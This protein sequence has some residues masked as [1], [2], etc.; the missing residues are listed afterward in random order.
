MKKIEL[1]ILLVF[2]VCF[3]VSSLISSCSNEEEIQ[4]KENVIDNL[5]TAVNRQ[6]ITDLFI[7]GTNSNTVLQELTK[8]Q[9]SY[10][11]FKDEIDVEKSLSEYKE[12]S[13][14]P[15]QYKEFLTPFFQEIKDLNDSEIIPKIEEYKIILDQSNLSDIDKNNLMFTLFSFKEV[16]QFSLEYSDLHNKKNSKSQAKG[17]CGRALGQ[18]LVSGFV[19]GCIRGG[20]TGAVAGTVTVPV[21]GTVTGAVGGCIANGAITGVISAF[22][23]WA[24]C[25]VKDNT[26]YFDETPIT[27]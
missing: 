10:Q 12:C 7:G 6:L 17:G 21:I 5:N 24:W 16:T 13:D 4:T 23:A 22:S 11:K 9:K 25:A 1:K 15:K 2:I 3:S 14:C 20:I 27:P 18:G 8:G 19:A 26:I